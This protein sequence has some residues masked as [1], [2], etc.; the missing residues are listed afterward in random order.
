MRRLQV[1][2]LTHQLLE[3]HCHCKSS[4]SPS[5]IAHYLSNCKPSLLLVVMY[6]AS[7][8][9]VSK[10]SM[11]RE[12]CGLPRDPLRTSDLFFWVLRG[13]RGELPPIGEAFMRQSAFGSL[14]ADITG[15]SIF[16]IFHL[17]FFW[18]LPCFMM[19]DAVR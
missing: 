18:K 15:A 12:M 6:R 10:E 13:I 14:G 9:M 17:L 16:I 11:F 1:G 4:S 2:S 3:L 7:S 19:I 5:L 8:G